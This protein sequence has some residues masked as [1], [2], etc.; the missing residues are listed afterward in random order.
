MIAFKEGWEPSSP[1]RISDEQAKEFLKS[2]F[3]SNLQPPPP[4]F[5]T[6]SDS[7]PQS[8]H[9]AE[10]LDEIFYSEGYSKIGMIISKD[11]YSNL[12]FKIIHKEK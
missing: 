4:S 10:F 9:I 8:L 3:S 7:N 1:L 2:I 11:E 12:V 6:S 5:P